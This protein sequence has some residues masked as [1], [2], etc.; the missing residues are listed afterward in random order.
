MYAVL[1]LPV[2][3]GF[4]SLGIDLARVRLTKSELATAADAAARHGAS[5]LPNGNDAVIAA[6]VTTAAGNSA[7]GSPVVLD[8]NTDVTVGT[9]N[10][11]T[12]VFSSGGANPNAVKVILDRAGNALYFSRSVIPFARAGSPCFL[13]HQG[14]YGYSVKFLLQFVK[15][16]PGVLEQ[17]EQLE[18]LRALENTARI[19]V[20]LTKTASLGVDA[21]EDAALVERLLAK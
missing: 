14:I 5:F 8:P 7:G 19:R 2:L 21:P 4:V 16:K 12:K 1:L 13:R 9:W 11:A 18:Q 10:S 17:C 20:V 15:W 3:F 6:A